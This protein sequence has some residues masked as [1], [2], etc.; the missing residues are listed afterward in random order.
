[1]WTRDEI[2][3]V[4]G[5]E[6]D[7][8]AY[9]YGLQ[10]RVAE[11][12]DDVSAARDTL[13]D[14]TGGLSVRHSTA[15]TAARFG[16]SD[17]EVRGSLAASRRALFAARAARPRPARDDKVLVAWNGLMLSALARAAQT[18]DDAQYLEAARTAAG[19]I[20]A[21][22]YDAKTGSLKRRYRQGDVDIDAQLEDYA[23]LIQG[24]LD[25]YEASFEPRWLVWAAR[26]QT[27]QD[28]LFWDA[29]DGGYFST[30]ADAPDVIARA[31]EE[32]DG[33]EPAGNSVAA[34]NL[35]RLSQVTGRPAWRDKADATFTALSVR[36]TR[37]AAALPQLAAA[38][39]FAT[40]KPKEIV[41]AGDPAAADTHALL[42]LVHDRFIP[43]KV[44]LVA[45][46]GARQAEL[47]PLV[48]FLGNMTRR[49]GRATIYVCENYACRLPTSDPATAARLLDAD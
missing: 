21:R 5:R 11:S 30:R 41:I 4:L 42:R 7:L 25:L 18:F 6:A 2:R 12:G 49:N 35:L 19:F 8:F 13:G 36:F 28:A 26:L 1:V 29:K 3:G 46:G 22:M 16:M 44:L 14:M 34:M 32:R 33:A 43:N 40:S 38:L 23:F 24:L 48:P 15:E 17:R 9:H 39:D 10:G 31:K 20:E 27:T 47:T 37:S 45:D